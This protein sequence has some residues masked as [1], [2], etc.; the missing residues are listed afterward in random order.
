MGDE[1]PAETPWAV[2]KRMRAEGHPR[3][4]IVERLKAMGLDDGD[5]RVL[6]FT[7]LSLLWIA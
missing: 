7:P 6:L 5:V 4:V 1:T 3:N 2:A